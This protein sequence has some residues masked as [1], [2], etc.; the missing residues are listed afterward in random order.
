MP[1]LVIL[2]KSET[3]K[4]QFISHQLNSTTSLASPGLHRVLVMISQNALLSSLPHI[5]I[6]LAPYYHLVA[7]VMSNKRRSLCRSDISKHML[8]LDPC[9]AELLA[10]HFTQI[11]QPVHV[12]HAHC[13]QAIHQFTFFRWSILA[14]EAVANVT[15]KMF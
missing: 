8:G 9:P 14:I 6:D 11:Y 5:V 3:F 12:G 4:T 2:T 10:L 7:A 15:V 1:L 13:I